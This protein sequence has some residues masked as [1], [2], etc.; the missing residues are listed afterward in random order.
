MAKSPRKS[1]VAYATHF[2][3]SLA[4][5]YVAP[6]VSYRMSR[7]VVRGV[8][9]NE[10]GV[11]GVKGPRQEKFV[12]FSSEKVEI[13]E[14]MSLN[15]R[16]DANVTCP[17]VNVTGCQVV[18]KNMDLCGSITVFRGSLT[19]VNCRI[20]A[21]E[22]T[23]ESGPLIHGQNGAKIEI[24]KCE[25][26]RCD[27]YG[28]I[29]EMHSAVTVKDSRFDGL[30]YVAIGAYLHSSLKVT[31]CTFNDMNRDC[32]RVLE[33]C[34]GEVVNCQFTGKQERALASSEADSV[35]FK[36]CQVANCTSS[37]LSVCD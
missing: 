35:I 30:Q 15:F 19:L 1:P 28:V 26:G 17:H 37:S 8:L 36:R 4:A 31:S 16:R 34:T 21:V 11:A 6:Q 20:R 12:D 29:V 14:S 13:T 2:L 32:I 5:V 22:G 3:S 23:D 7:Y 25:F 18:I 24:S 33:R 10:K 27:Y 9:L